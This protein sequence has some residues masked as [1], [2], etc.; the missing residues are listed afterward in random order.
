M[1]KNPEIEDEIIDEEA[2]NDYQLEDMKIFN[3][4]DSGR[5]KFEKSDEDKFELYSDETYSTVSEP[6]K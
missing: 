5:Q 2:D 4:T 1:S 3:S 6:T